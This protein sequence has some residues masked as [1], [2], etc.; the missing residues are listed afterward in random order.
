MNAPSK[1]AVIARIVFVAVS[2]GGLGFA[3]WGGFWG[4]MCAVAGGVLAH[5]AL[6]AEPADVSHLRD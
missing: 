3:L 4:T 2:A 5:L 6:I 1:F